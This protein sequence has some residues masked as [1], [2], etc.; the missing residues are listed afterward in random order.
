[1]KKKN[2]KRS[3]LGV[4]EVLDTILLLGIAIS[5]FS[6]LSVIVLSYPFDPPSPNVNLIG[7]VDQNDIIVD[8]KGGEDLSLETKIIIRINKTNSYY[9][10]V[11][12]IFDNNLPDAL[13]NNLWNI[14]ERLVINS[15]TDLNEN[16]EHAS[17]D[18]TIVDV[19][20]NTV[21]MMGVIQEA[22]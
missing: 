18:L 13:N 8:H 2:K 21:I 17:V 6:I 15:T 19:E 11:F 20:S 16:I 4:S 22:S 14:G 12:E 3:D 10:T 9:M 7:F 5:M 1:M